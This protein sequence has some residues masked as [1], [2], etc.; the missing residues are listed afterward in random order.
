MK[1]GGESSNYTAEGEGT[2]DAQSVT[3]YMEDAGPQREGDL[4]KR[5]LLAQEPQAR[6]SPPSLCPPPTPSHQEPTLDSPC[7]PHGSR[8]TCNVHA[9]GICGIPERQAL[10]LDLVPQASHPTPTM[11]PLKQKSQCRAGEETVGGGKTLSYDQNPKARCAKLRSCGSPSSTP[12]SAAR[13]QR[14][15]HQNRGHTKCTTSL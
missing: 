4:P 3:F 7:L 9:R 1:R 5:T 13:V 11:S 8:C 15:G 14:C 10:S 12:S 6:A 2:G